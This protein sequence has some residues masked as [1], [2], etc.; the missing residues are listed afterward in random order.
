MVG[1]VGG[2]DEDVVHI[3]VVGC[4]YALEDVVEEARE[5]GGAGTHAK[6]QDGPSIGTACVQ[7]RKRP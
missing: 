2:V 1:H 6:G 4:V 3:G 7:V 5:D